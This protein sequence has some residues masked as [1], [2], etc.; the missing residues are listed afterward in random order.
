MSARRVALT[1]VDV[2]MQS[3]KE[4]ASDWLDQNFKRFSISPRDRTFITELVYGTLRRIITLD[5]ILSRYTFHR[6]KDHLL[7]SILRLG[8]Y[9]IYFLDKVPQYAVVNEMVEITKEHMG[10]AKARFVNA[11]LRRAAARDVKVTEE[12]QGHAPVFPLRGLSVAHSMPMWFLERW[13]KTYN[14]E[15]LRQICVASNATPEIFA[16]VNRIKSTCAELKVFFEQEGVRVAATP[17]DNVFSIRP[18]KSIE[19]LESFRKGLF[20]V[21]DPTTMRI[22]DFMKPDPADRILDMC[23]APG[24]KSFYMEEKTGRG[25]NILALEKNPLRLKLGIE[26]AQR[27]GS[28]VAW[29]SASDFQCEASGKFDKILLDVPCSNQGVLARRVE[30]RWRLTPDRVEKLRRLQLELLGQ[31]L[32]CVNAAGAIYY[33][34]C[35]IDQAENEGL[36][37]E[38]VKRHEGWKCESALRILPAAGEHDGGFVAKLTCASLKRSKS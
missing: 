16:R 35:S 18:P 20:Y 32:S 19:S 33:S 30:A 37:G 7:K 24:G 28:K 23:A 34:T 22:V 9:Q 36:V 38:F 25:E 4:L 3:D 14:R 6:V 11:V 13:A 5:W 29:M 21:Q 26:N 10:E 8:I 31:A 27:L 1:I 17:D 15:E 2:V 12:I